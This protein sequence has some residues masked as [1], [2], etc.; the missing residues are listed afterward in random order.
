MK[1]TILG[2][3]VF[4]SL[5]LSAPKDKELFEEIQ[6]LKQEIVKTQ[7]DLEYIKIQNAN[8]KDSLDKLYV[9]DL[10]PFSKK[11]YKN[12]EEVS[13]LSRFFPSSN[14]LLQSGCRIDP[15]I[16]PSLFVALTEY[17]GPPIS[18]TSMRRTY[19]FGSKHFSGKAVD[20][21]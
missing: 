19:N 18:L 3:L 6:I 17:S 5:S 1:S 13:N 21:Q 2:A 8:L 14:I 4:L 11:W 9:S 20:I 10:K 12:Y 15:F 7:Q 16:N